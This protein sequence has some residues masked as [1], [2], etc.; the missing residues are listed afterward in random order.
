V[1]KW[2]DQNGSNDHAQTTTTQ[3]PR[4]VDSGVADEGFVFDGSNDELTST[5]TVG[6]TVTLAFWA[7]FVSGSTRTVFSINNGGS[8]L[9]YNGST[10][11]A[12]FP[13]TATTQL[14]ITIANISATWAHVA[15]TQT[16]TT[17]CLYIDGSLVETGTTAAMAASASGTIIGR[18]AGGNAMYGPLRDVRIYSVAKSALEVAA[19]KASVTP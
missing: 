3:Q 13:N 8:V 18:F 14:N 17:Y 4:I 6:T 5:L 9:R 1:T 15:L 19:I 2:Y 7:K 12:W 11:M 10:T 16:G